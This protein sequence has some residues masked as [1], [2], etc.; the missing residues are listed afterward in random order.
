MWESLWAAG[1][2]SQE[3]GGGG[4]SSG[5]T[6]PRLELNL[7]GAVIVF[8]FF[9]QEMKFIF[10]AIKPWS[11]KSAYTEASGIDLEFVQWVEYSRDFL[12]CAEGELYH[13]VK[14]KIPK[15]LAPRKQRD[16]RN[17]VKKMG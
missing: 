8:F 10:A 14:D 16:G 15:I 1:K 17:T 2:D 6:S 3:Q 4:W 13:F 7:L 11:C 9:F 5:E 12:S